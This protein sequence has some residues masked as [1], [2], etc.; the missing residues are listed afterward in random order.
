MPQ[1]AH[2]DDIVFSSA[3]LIA[4]NV[5]IEMRPYFDMI[6]FQRRMVEKIRIGQ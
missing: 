4:N 5:V 3:V 6:K 2:F 1:A